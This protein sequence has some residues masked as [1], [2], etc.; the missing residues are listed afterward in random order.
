M[1]E[2]ER[3]RVK[4]ESGIGASAG[5][6]VKTGKRERASESSLKGRSD[7]TPTP[8]S[9]LFPRHLSPPSLTL[10]VH[11]LFPSFCVGSSVNFSFSLSLS[12]T[13]TLPLRCLFLPRRCFF[14]TSTFLSLPS[15]SHTFFSS[16]S[17]F[18]EFSPS[19]FIPSPSIIFCLFLKENHKCSFYSDYLS[20]S[21]SIS[22]S[23]EKTSPC[24][25]SVLLI[26]TLFFFFLVTL[27]A[28]L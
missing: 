1:R 2:R 11:S 15:Y 18:H 5:H 10:V 19:F 6:M 16:S 3:E 20:L 23:R 12:H 9:S 25:S 4:E 17:I 28:E 7:Y 21:F 22:D 8:L 26:V 27:A 13:R 14:S 24:L